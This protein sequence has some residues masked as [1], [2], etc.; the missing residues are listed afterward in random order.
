MGTEIIHCLGSFNSRYGLSFRVRV[1]IDCG[2]AHLMWGV[3]SPKPRFVS[4]WQGCLGLPNETPLTLNSQE[5]SVGWGEG[6]KGSG[7]V[8]CR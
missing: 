2:E 7:D 5:K 3:P 1:G 4:L 6:E 8:M